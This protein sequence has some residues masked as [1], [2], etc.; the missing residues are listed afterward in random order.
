MTSLREVALSYEAPT[1]GNIA[2]LETVPVDIDVQ[3]KTFKEGTDDQ[4]TVKF[5]TVDEK[6][7]RVPNSVVMQLQEILTIKP[8]TTECK[9]TKKGTGLNTT[10]TVVPL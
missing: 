4:F 9:V 10:Y 3:E 7:Y 5:C 2:D 8:D 6:D 1:M